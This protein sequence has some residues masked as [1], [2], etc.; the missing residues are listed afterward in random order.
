M[1]NFTKPSAIVT[2]VAALLSLSAGV[3]FQMVGGIFGAMKYNYYN[4]LIVGLLIGGLVLTVL[5]LLCKLPGLASFVATAVPGVS[6]C[7]FFAL[8]DRPPYW[9]IVDV[10][11]G[12]DEKAFDPFFLTFCI[13]LV[14]AFILGEVAIY[15]RKQPKVK[16]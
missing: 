9:H 12:I 8:G 5:L 7:L 10:F 14:V 4:P 16:A 13:L 15:L 1:K 2:L 11:M 3:L 6:L